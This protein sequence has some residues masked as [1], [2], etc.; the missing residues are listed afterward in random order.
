[1]SSVDKGLEILRACDVGFLFSFPS[2]FG[3]G[4]ALPINLAE[5]QY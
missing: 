1:M 2:S 4:L 5:S 3:D